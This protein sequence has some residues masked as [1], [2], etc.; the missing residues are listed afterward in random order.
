MKLRFVMDRRRCR[1][2]GGGGTPVRVH[3]VSSGLL[4]RDAGVAIAG[5]D[6]VDHDVVLACLPRCRLQVRGANDIQPRHAVGEGGD[7]SS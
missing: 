2:R 7:P 3:E 6:T 4:Q 1:S 5:V